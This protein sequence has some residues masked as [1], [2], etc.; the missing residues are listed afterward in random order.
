MSLP[1][2]L[3]FLAAVS[4]NLRKKKLLES[5][6]FKISAGVMISAKATSQFS[7]SICIG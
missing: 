1:D 7:L 3:S 4:V 5:E 6:I 2:N